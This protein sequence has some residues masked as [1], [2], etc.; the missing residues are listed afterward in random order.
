MPAG[1]CESC[2]CVSALGLDE[3]GIK[4]ALDNGNEFEEFVSDIEA[5]GI[6]IAPAPEAA[7][8]TAQPEPAPAPTAQLGARA[9]PVDFE[10]AATPVGPAEVAGITTVVQGEAPNIVLTVTSGDPTVICRVSLRPPTG[11]WGE[12]RPPH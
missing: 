3:D 8:P 2:V 7:P 4:I 12:G 1:V 10:E 6:L 9:Q 5:R 11:L